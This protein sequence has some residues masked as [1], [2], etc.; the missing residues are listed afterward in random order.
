MAHVAVQQGARTPCRGISDVL[1]FVAGADALRSTHEAEPLTRKETRM[2]TPE[3]ATATQLRNIE[4]STGR[5]VQEWATLID[6]AGI[7]KHTEIVAWLKSTHGLTHGNANLLARKVRDAAEGAPAAD[8]DLLEAQYAGAK[9]ALRPIYDAVVKAA[10]GLGSD[11][12]V[13]VQK[14]GV[15]LRRRKQFGLVTVP[16]AKRVE[17]GLNLAGFEP[18][19]RL[20]ASSGMCTHRVNLTAP[21][22]VDAELIAWLTDAYGRAE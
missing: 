15:S 12:T 21:A 3:E 11:V 6:K 7:T 20:L 16:S 18:T 9:L 2:A 4:E 22:E 17:L 1:R 5:T 14:T 19:D 13:V 8:G 10:Q